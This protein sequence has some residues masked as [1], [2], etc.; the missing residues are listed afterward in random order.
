MLRIT[1]LVALILMSACSSPLA[2]RRAQVMEPG[3]LE[4]SV[5]PYGEA[6][7]VVA[8][9]TPPQPFAYPSGE[10]TARIGIVERMDLQLKVDPTIIPEFNVAYQ[11]LGDPSKNEFALTLSGGVKPSVIFLPIAGVVVGAGLITTPL[12]AIVDVPLNDHAVIVVGTRIIPAYI[13]ANAGVSGVGALTVA[14]GVFGALHIGNDQ[15][16]FRPELAVN[17]V[18]PLIASSGTT[19]SPLL[20]TAGS[21]NIAAGLG[22]GMT[23]DFT[24]DAP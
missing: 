8:K 7:A 3:E 4:I 23:F 19:T 14:P 18:I 24:P 10:I 1:S 11:V 22:V 5:V 20:G 15:F 6:S 17:G 16:F 12:E 21:F 13:F 9:G 2:S